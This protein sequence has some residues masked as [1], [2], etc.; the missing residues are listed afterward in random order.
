MSVIRWP[1]AATLL[2]D[3]PALLTSLLMVI[4]LSLL[5][6]HLI[7]EVVAWKRQAPGPWGFPIVGHLHLLGKF[8]QLTFLEMAKR[9]GDIFRIRVGKWPTLVLNGRDA[10][11]ECLLRQGRVFAG[12]PAFYSHRFLARGKRG[13]T[14]NNYSERWELQHKLIVAAFKQMPSSKIQDT[15]VKHTTN[16]IQQLR[17]ECSMGA[18]VDPSRFI[19]RNVANIIYSLSFGNVGLDPDDDNNWC[20]LYSQVKDFLDFQSTSVPVDFLP[21]T[22]FFYREAEKRFMRLSS[23]LERV[24]RV[25]LEEHQRTY[26]E[27]ATRDILDAIISLSR[28]VPEETKKRL[29]LSTEDIL[30]TA[31]EL[32]GPGFDTISSAL[33]WAV[34]YMAAHPEVQRKVHA[35]IDKVNIDIFDL[36][37][38]PETNRVLGFLHKTQFHTLKINMYYTLPKKNVN[39]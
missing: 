3:F 5:A 9:Y 20:F 30:F 18:P 26:E 14:M 36:F 37:C 7:K 19:T 17:Q 8:P 21:W 6:V 23:T 28:T 22:R 1:R 10:I 35:E 29:S 33:Q 39:T 31:H 25:K 11:N 27:G 38:I 12:R 16:L 34:L 2:G 13:F 24:F 15:T 4:A 32:L